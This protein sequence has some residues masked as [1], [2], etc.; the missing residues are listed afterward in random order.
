MN[1]IE[2]K[3][4]DIVREFED[5]AD[6]QEK[7]EYLIEMGFDLPPLDAQYKVEEKR[8]LGCQSNVWLHS[9]YLSD[10]GLM[11]YA[12]DSDSMIVKGLISMLI[13]VLSEQRPED[14]VTTRLDFLN[15]IGLDRHLS[16]TRSNGLASM[17][18]EMKQQAALHLGAVEA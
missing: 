13:Q 3:Q 11:H 5:F 1:S 18:K 16:S 17:V 7:Y 8:I 10:Q 15:Q 12:A 2:Q 9:E 14:I 6:W 4:H